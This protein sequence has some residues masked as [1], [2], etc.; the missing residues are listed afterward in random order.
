MVESN[1]RREGPTR[2][3]E[4]ACG[5]GQS[6][7]VLSV[8]GDVHMWPRNSGD[9]YRVAQ[10]GADCVC[11]TP[12]SRGTILSALFGANVPGASGVPHSFSKKRAE[13]D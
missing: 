4:W 7:R 5:C 6:Y 13:V 2:S 8:N 10:V 12:L 9:G 3:G 11:G 1:G